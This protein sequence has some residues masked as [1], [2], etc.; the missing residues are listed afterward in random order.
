MPG[1]KVLGVGKV[2]DWGKFLGGLMEKVVG[3][4]GGRLLAGAKV[5][6]TTILC[7][8]ALTL[9]LAR[10]VPVLKSSGAEGVLETRG[11]LCASWVDREEG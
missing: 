10:G 6:G 3:G 1:W 9:P 11:R 5:P 4:L 8:R 7:G 2:L